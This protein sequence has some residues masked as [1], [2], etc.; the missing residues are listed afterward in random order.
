MKKVTSN[1]TKHVEAEKEITDLTNKVVQISE[2]GHDG[3]QNFLVFAPMLSSLILDNNKEV[4]NWILTRISSKNIKPFDTYLEPTMS[5]L[6]NGRVILKFNN[7]VLLQKDFS[8]LYSNF[9]LNL[10]L[11]CELNNRPCNTTNNF[12]LKSCFFGTIKLV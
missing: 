9:I 2:K 5:N 7:S 4:T 12:N 8:S 11:F 10:Y 6:A 1:K 3:Y